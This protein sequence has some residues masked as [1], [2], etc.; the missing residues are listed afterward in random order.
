MR[1][2]CN[3][4]SSEKPSLDPAIEVIDIDGAACK[5]IAGENDAAYG[6]LRYAGGGGVVVRHH[7]PPQPATAITC[8]GNRR[9]AQRFAIAMDTYLPLLSVSGT[10]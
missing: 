10:T 7:S 9:E 1:Q 6:R 8:Y 3:S 2:C 4:R 5:N